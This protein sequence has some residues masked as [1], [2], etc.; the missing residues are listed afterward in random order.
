M[1][2]VKDGKRVP[3]VAHTLNPVPC[4][5]KDY[6]GANAWK[7]NTDSIPIPGLSHVA[8]TLCNLLGFQA[9][10]DYDPSLIRL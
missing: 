8:A 3:H 2:T 10:G 1:F 7:M 4:I 5:V 6:S 9:P